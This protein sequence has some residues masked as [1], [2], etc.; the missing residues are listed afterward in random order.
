MY[1]AYSPLTFYCSHSASL[2]L[3]RRKMAKPGG[4]PIEITCLDL[5]KRCICRGTASVVAGYG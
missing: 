3:F 2:S 1:L 5:S 4:G